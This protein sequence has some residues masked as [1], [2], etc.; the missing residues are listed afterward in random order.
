MSPPSSPASNKPLRT[1]P[2]TPTSLN[3]PSQSVGNGAHRNDRHP[4]DELLALAEAVKQVLL[5]SE[6]FHD[7]FNEW[8]GEELPEQG[9][10]VVADVVPLHDFVE[11]A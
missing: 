1:N 8:F 3:E 4:P 10:L 5:F 7:E 6:D 9:L 2:G 11:S